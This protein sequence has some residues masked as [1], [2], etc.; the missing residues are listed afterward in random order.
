M[1]DRQ[2]A[3]N[4]QISDFL[5]EFKHRFTTLSHQGMPGK[6]AYSTKLTREENC[7]LNIYLSDKFP[8][9]SPIMYVVPK[10]PDFIL[11][12]TG[13]VKDTCV[14]IWN[15]HSRLVN[16]VRT[17]LLKLEHNSDHSLGISSKGLYNINNINNTSNNNVNLNSNSNNVGLGNNPYSVLLTNNNINNNN[18]NIYSNQQSSYSTTNVSNINSMNSLYSNNYNN[19]TNSNMYSNTN[20]VNQNFI[21]MGNGLQHNS[22]Y[23]NNTKLSNSNNNIVNINSV[24][25]DKPYSNSFEYTKKN[26]DNFNIGVPNDNSGSYFNNN[27][28][29]MD[30]KKN[31]KSIEEDLNSKSVEELIYIFN[32][33]DEYVK[34]Y[35]EPYKQSSYDLKNEVDKIS[36]KKLYL[37][38]YFNNKFITF[39]NKL[40]VYLLFNIR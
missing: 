1:I 13:R 27:T 19:N 12:D 30:T 11:D 38:Y 3:Y 35:M 2:Q 6:I 5:A 40:F 4:T 18:N 8:L 10:I 25:N 28:F 26:D 7:S 36:G 29:S 24:I 23:N 37:Y 39:N 32:N 31:Y 9:D 22:V 14:T 16:A 34:D 33:Q 15:I 20:N 17:V 21:P